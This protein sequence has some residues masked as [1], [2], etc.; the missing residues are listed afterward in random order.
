MHQKTFFHHNT[1][2]GVSVAVTALPTRHSQF[3]NKECIDYCMDSETK[4]HP[5]E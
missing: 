1:S 5:K 4:K 3:A 2:T